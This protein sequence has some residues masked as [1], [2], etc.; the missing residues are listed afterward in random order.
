MDDMYQYVES[1]SQEYIAT[2]IPQDAGSHLSALPGMKPKTAAYKAL[3]LPQ[4]P[5]TC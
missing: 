1:S 5:A 2:Q 4:R 3:T